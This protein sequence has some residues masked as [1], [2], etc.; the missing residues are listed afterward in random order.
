MLFVSSLA[1]FNSVQTFLTTKLTRRV[2]SRAPGSVNPLQARTFGVWTLMSAAVRI[3]AAYHIENKACVH[4]SFLSPV[5]LHTL[6]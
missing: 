2:Y 5:L 6:H 4:F 3:Y 1:V